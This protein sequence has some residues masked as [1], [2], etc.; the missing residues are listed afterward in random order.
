MTPVLLFLAP[1]L[2]AFLAGLLAWGGRRASRAA[3]L[4]GAAAALGLALAAGFQSLGGDLAYEMGGWAAPWGIEIRLTPFACFWTAALDALCLA[5]LALAPREGAARPDP[6]DAVLLLLTGSAAALVLD[7][8]LFD[9]YLWVELALLGAGLLAAREG[10]PWTAF[11]IAFWGSVG[12]SFLLLGVLFL[13]SGTGTLDLGDLLS[14]LLIL[15]DAA[16]KNFR[17][18]IG[19]GG[20]WLT[21][22]LALPLM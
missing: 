3:A 11:R 14:Q 13:Y 6:F 20:F 5:A 4:L 18:L 10:S 2:A 12:A 21:L 7:R 19:F 22:G 8:D 9:A 15:Q 1:F 16:P 17:A